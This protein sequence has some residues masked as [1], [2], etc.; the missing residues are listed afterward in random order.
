[1]IHGVK[2]MGS[3]LFAW[4]KQIHEILAYGLMALHC[5]VYP[6]ACPQTQIKPISLLVADIRITTN[7]V[8]NVTFS[9]ILVMYMT[10]EMG[11]V[12][13]EFMHLYVYALLLPQ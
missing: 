3:R 2:E 12:G 10:A 6:C 1:M 7:S 13:G 11:Q 4:L 9:F 8:R 5:I